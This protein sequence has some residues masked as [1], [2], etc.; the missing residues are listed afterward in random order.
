M[1][2]RPQADGRFRV[3]A[4][5]SYIQMVRFPKNGLPVVESINSYGASAR[6][7]SAH[8]TDQMEMY[9]GK[10]LRRMTFDKSTV[11]ATAEK[12]YHPGDFH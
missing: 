4:G 10:R 11:L 9:I 6:P 1:Y 12:V 2:S 5:E 8:Y 7:E 3:V